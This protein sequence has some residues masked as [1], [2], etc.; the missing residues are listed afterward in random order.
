LSSQPVSR[1]GRLRHSY[2]TRTWCDSYEYL[3]FH[4][5]WNGIL[6]KMT[7]CPAETVHTSVN[8][9]MPKCRNADQPTQPPTDRKPTNQTNNKPKVQ[10]HASKQ[11]ASPKQTNTSLSTQTMLL[12]ARRL[13]PLACRNFRQPFSLAQSFTTSHS[14]NMGFEK[15]VSLCSLFHSFPRI[16]SSDLCTDRYCCR[17]CMRSC[18]TDHQGRQ[19]AA[20]DQGT[21]RYCSLHRV[22]NSACVPPIL[23]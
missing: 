17:V 8:P 10:L 21:D 6:G 22:R 20:A 19:W 16:C 1:R 9:E 3:R 11:P 23:T 2:E 13:A 15:Q 14:P 4:C 12:L 5:V 7:E 18:Q